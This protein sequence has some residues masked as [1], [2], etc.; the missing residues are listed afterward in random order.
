[1]KNHGGKRDFNGNEMEIPEN[2]EEPPE[3]S[4]GA[5]KPENIKL[6]ENKQNNAENLNNSNKIA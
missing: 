4:N 2:M 6:P 1:M 5:E 3:M